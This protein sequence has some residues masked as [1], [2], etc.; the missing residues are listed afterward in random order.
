M[1]KHSVRA[2]SDTIRCELRQDKVQVITLEPTFY[3][4]EIV[5]QS[6][7]SNTRDRLFAE[8]SDDTKAHYQ[9]TNLGNNYDKTQGM[10]GK[11]VRSNIGEVVDAMVKAVILKHPKPFFRCCGYPDL[12]AWAVSHAPEVLLDA[13]FHHTMHN[14]FFRFLTRL[15]VNVLSK[16]IK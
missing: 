1:A 2:F 5:N 15:S 8:S 10:A 12:A 7:L 9:K 13:F 3:Q 4:T 14:R 16:F 11:L 6:T